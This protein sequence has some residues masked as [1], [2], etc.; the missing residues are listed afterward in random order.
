MKHSLE[1]IENTAYKLMWVPGLFWIYDV[2]LLEKI[3][4]GEDDK[5]DVCTFLAHAIYGALQIQLILELL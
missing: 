2:I 3:F 1:S 4:S 5:L